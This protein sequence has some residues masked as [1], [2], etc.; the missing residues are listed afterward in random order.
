[1]VVLVELWIPFG[2]GWGGIGWTVE[3]APAAESG[4]VESEAAWLCGVVAPSEM[5][6]VSETVIL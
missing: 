5:G 1:M 6:V 4:V 2:V 3:V